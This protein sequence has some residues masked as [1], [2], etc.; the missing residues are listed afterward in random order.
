MASAIYFLNSVDGV[1]HEAYRT[2]QRLP[3]ACMPFIEPAD[4]KKLLD[5]RASLAFESGLHFIDRCTGMCLAKLLPT[6]T[7]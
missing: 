4:K 3:C 1:L 5:F 6:L 7:T 2:G